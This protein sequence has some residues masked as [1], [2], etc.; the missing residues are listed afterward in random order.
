MAG[1]EKKEKSGKVPY[2]PPKLFSLGGS[3]AYAAAPCNPGGSPAGGNC[4]SG[5]TATSAQCMVGNAA[6]GK[7]QSGS[8]ATGGKCQNG[9]FAGG[10]CSSG[11]SPN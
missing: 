10:K 4:K 7:C 5:S 2:E 9:S 11:G 3:T 8:A 6:G 1:E